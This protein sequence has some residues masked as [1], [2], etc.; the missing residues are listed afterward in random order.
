MTDTPIVIGSKPKVKDPGEVEEIRKGSLRITDPATAQDHRE[1]RF[2]APEVP[3]PVL[4]DTVNGPL[5]ENVV[6]GR[7]LLAT[8]PL[9]RESIEPSSEADDF[10]LSALK[11]D[12]E[13][14]GAQRLEII[15][16]GVGPKDFLGG[17]LFGRDYF[18][19]DQR[20]REMAL[21]ELRYNEDLQREAMKLARAEVARRRDIGLSKAKFDYETSHKAAI[22]REAEVEG[23]KYD[24]GEYDRR[25]GV[26]EEARKK[27]GPSKLEQ[28]ISDISEMLKQRGLK[29]E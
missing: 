13:D 9:T 3:P 22:A 26:R 1:A 19:A 17:L 23:R 29:L 12:G 18:Q 10:A 24:A 25:V 14:Y 11:G 21:N 7:P 27:R 6:E 5:A 15:N 20:H 28:G 4:D 2:R 16:K 8:E